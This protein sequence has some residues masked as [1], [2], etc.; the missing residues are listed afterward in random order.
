MDLHFSGR[1]DNLQEILLAE[2]SINGSFILN[3]NVYLNILWVTTILKLLDLLYNKW[4][5]YAT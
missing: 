2:S 5:Q 4:P 3:K 1:T